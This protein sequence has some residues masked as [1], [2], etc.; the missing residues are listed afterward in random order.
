MFQKQCWKSIACAFLVQ[1]GLTILIGSR[2]ELLIYPV[3]AFNGYAENFRKSWRPA[4]KSNL[5]SVDKLGNVYHDDISESAYTSLQRLFIGPMGDFGA[6]SISDSE[7][8]APISML[9]P[10]ARVELSREQSHYLIKVLRIF[11]KGGGEQK[12]GLIRCFDG[13]NGEVKVIISL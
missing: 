13:L 3:N 8:G 4:D 10:N 6:T 12:R 7:K 9:Q 5:F 2:S 1:S 11:S